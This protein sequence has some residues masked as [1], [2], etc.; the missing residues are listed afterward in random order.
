MPEKT[1]DFMGELNRSEAFCYVTKGMTV[2]K[3]DRGN[4]CSLKEE[5][6][7]RELAVD[8]VAG[9]REVAKGTDIAISAPAN[10]APSSTVALCI[11][12]SFNHEDFCPPL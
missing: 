12:N 10:E 3:C 6:R 2:V 8:V 5:E 11:T 7:H 4:P 9:I 1:L